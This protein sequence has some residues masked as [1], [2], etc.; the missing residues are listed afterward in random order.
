MIRTLENLYDFLAAETAWRK[1][2]LSALVGLV[3]SNHLSPSRRDAFVRAAITLLYAHWEGFVK[4]AGAAYLEYVAMQRLTHA[5]LAANFLALS[6]RSTLTSAIQ[7][8]KV[9]AYLQI[10]ELFRTQMA[11]QSK[12]AYRTLL[13]TEGNLS[14]RVLREIVEMLG[15]DYAPFITKEKL[16][17]ES[18][19]WRRNTIA[20]GSYLPVDVSEFLQLHNEFVSLIEVFRNQIDNS[21][22]LRRYRSV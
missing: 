8:T 18:L 2:E 10:V 19:L 14:S 6:I 17:D 5:E 4:S 22:A 13:T 3:E 20:H 21:A 7:S 15:L 9:G 1:K 12:L 16:I 11:A